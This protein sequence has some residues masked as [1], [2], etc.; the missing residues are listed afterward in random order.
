MRSMSRRSV[1]GH[2]DAT[3]P[4]MMLVVLAA[5]PLLSAGWN[6]WDPM[7]SLVSWVVDGAVK[8]WRY[9]ADYALKV[10]GM[11]Q[12]DW[13]TASLV[14][15]RVAG[16]CA[17]GAV[18]AGAWQ[19]CRDMLA[20]RL[21]D[22][23]VDL[24]RTVLA[25]PLT[26]VAI[27]LVV[28]ATSIADDMTT[29]ILTSFGGKDALN[30]SFDLKVDVDKSSMGP[31]A[32]L[33]LAVLIT[34]GSCVLV[35]TMAARNFLL[36]LG[37]ALIAVPLMLQGMRSLRPL[38]ATYARWILGIIL[39]QPLIAVLVWMTGQ[40]MSS[41]G[42]GDIGF[43]TGCV[44]AVLSC[45]LPWTLV[46]KV[47]QW[48]PGGNGLYA[49]ADAAKQT[50]GTAA[51]I[52]ATVAG[53]S[54]D[55]AAGAMREGANAL[56]DKSHGDD[57]QGG[58]PPDTSQ[59][60]GANPNGPS[61]P[62]SSD[63]ANT[64]DARHDGMKP[65]VKDARTPT[66]G[67][68]GG[69]G[70]GDAAAGAADSPIDS[71]GAAGAQQ[72]TDA[73]TDAEG[74]MET[75]QEAEAREARAKAARERG[76]RQ[77]AA[78][79]SLASNLPK[80]RMSALAGKAGD[81]AQAAGA[82]NAAKAMAG[83]D[84]DNN[85]G[86]DDGDGSG[87][88]KEPV[89]PFPSDD[90]RH[91]EFAR[92]MAARDAAIRGFFSGAAGADGA[93]SGDAGDDGMQGEASDMDAAD[94][95]QADTAADGNG[96]TDAGGSGAASQATAMGGDARPATTDGAGTAGAD[97]GDALA[98]RAAMQAADHGSAETAGMT[99]AATAGMAALSDASAAH[100]TVSPTMGSSPAAGSND[101][102]QGRSGAGDAPAGSSAGV[103]VPASYTAASAVGASDADMSSA[104][105]HAA[106]AERSA[107]PPSAAPMRRPGS[108]PPRPVASP[109]S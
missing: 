17:F 31:F 103:G 4:F 1:A 16:V 75:P 96:M 101:F 41:G 107:T 7:G 10:G 86:N 65:G 43:A 26:V 58:N 50:V 90:P 21:G 63:A 98:A 70:V 11:T 15:G 91:D 67:M 20:A 81:V 78:L 47:A 28:K 109:A 24:A 72:D 82:L 85:G 93:T 64:V 71:T 33:V 66:A 19:I 106:G 94:T 48:M 60:A 83:V 92:D 97:A 8:V 5:V 49:A 79:R 6:L 95:A 14:L 105:A 76:D 55:A 2:V 3:M 57:G 32:L 9:A 35:L 13:N 59:A 87:K 42:S 18:G 54:L 38:L 37:V 23:I 53:V 45:V 74:H 89:N 46:A 99:P 62:S 73:S 56:K 51:Q 40:M 44:G 69:T 22:V 80:G 30:K 36:I 25:W 77:A 108:P 104:M 100:A 27:T 88:A 61:S 29:R 34:I 39:I 52:A 84:A 68:P 12:K 102:A